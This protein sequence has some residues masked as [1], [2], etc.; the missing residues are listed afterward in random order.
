MARYL[1]GEQA[2][3]ARHAYT[4]EQFGLS[5]AK[6]T[7]RCGDYLKWLETRSSAAVP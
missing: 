2:A 1:E 7:D 6:V 3:K 5:Q 4:L